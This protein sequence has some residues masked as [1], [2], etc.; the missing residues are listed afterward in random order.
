[1]GCIEKDRYILESSPKKSKNR[2]LFGFGWFKSAK[3]LN[4]DLDGDD[5]TTIIKDT[6][7]IYFRLRRSLK[8]RK[9]QEDVDIL[10]EIAVK[11]ACLKSSFED[12]GTSRFDLLSLQDN[13]GRY[14]SIMSK[15]SKRHLN[16]NSRNMMIRLY[17]FYSRTYF[18]QTI[19]KFSKFRIETDKFCRN[20]ACLL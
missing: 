13:L 1:M 17:A 5:P 2:W 6:I 18:L 9:L 15:Y 7:K 3:K 8:K 4:S 14:Y 20:A 19:T 16:K 12:F 11:Q 10:K